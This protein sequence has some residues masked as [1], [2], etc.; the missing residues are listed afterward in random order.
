MSEKK[1]AD[2]QRAKA[3]IEA[4]ARGQATLPASRPPAHSFPD[5]K[6]SRRARR[7]LAEAGLR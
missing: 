6:P 2:Y 4:V 7:R 3:F 5:L 1:I